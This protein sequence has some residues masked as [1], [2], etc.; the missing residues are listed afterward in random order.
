MTKI[1]HERTSAFKICSTLAVLAFGLVLGMSA[2]GTKAIADPAIPLAG[3]WTVNTAHTDISFAITHFGLST[4]R[5]RFDTVSGTI[6]ADPDNLA[7][8]SVNFTIQA[9]SIDTNQSMRDND[10]KGKDYFDVADYPTITFVSTKIVKT[11]ADAYTA[12]GNLTMKGVT[13]EVSLPFK[14]LGPV[15]EMGQPKIGASS[16]ITIKRLDY[17]IGPNVP[18]LGY[19]VNVTISLEAGK[20]KAG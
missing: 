4:V 16:Q 18:I 5:G 9:S 12:K 3:I 8:S 20:A 14:V 6:V 2:S 19:D 1:N 17:G 10:I 15:N 13:K 7:K 11:G